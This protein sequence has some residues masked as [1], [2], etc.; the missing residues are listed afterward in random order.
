M[1]DLTLFEELINSYIEFIDE[2]GDSVLHFYST[3]KKFTIN[4]EQTNWIDIKIECVSKKSKYNSMADIIDNTYQGNIHEGELKNM[5]AVLFKM[6]VKQGCFSSIIRKYILMIIDN[7]EFNEDNIV[8]RYFLVIYAIDR[9]G[10]FALKLRF[11]EILYSN[12]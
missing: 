3:P 10:T 1:T 11:I 8:N 2:N 5:E 7:P 4:S 12:I 9:I 6:E